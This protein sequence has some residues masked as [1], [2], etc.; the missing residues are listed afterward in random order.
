MAEPRPNPP[1]P[2]LD[3]L[4]DDQSR[5]WHQG[6]RP[7]V[8]DYLR[9]HP[10]LGASPEN[11]LDLIYHELL[12]REHRGESP[13]LEEYLARFPHLDQAL[14][15]QF[16]VHRAAG[17]EETASPDLVGPAAD[18][19]SFGDYEIL[20]RVDEGGMGVVY[21]ARQLSLN[22]VVA[23][24]FV[25]LGGQAGGGELRR[26][27]MEAEN[28]ARL[29]HPNIVPVFEVGQHQGQPYFSM[30]FIDG[31]SLARLVAGREQ[32]AAG[33][34]GPRRAAQL[35]ATVA[36]AVQHAHERGILHRDLKPA[37]VLL[38]PAGSAGQPT[39]P[40][41]TDFGLA[42]RLEGDVGQTLSQS[43]AVV[44]TP[45]Y[46]APE[47]ATAQ[48]ELTTA[49]DVYGLGA[50]LYALLTGRPPFRAASVFETLQQVVEREPTPPRQL[51]RHVHLDLET[52][53]LKCLHKQPAQRYASAQEVADELERF[54]RGADIRARPAGRLELVRRWCRRNPALA[55]AS[56]LAVAALLAVTGVSVW[57]ALAESRHTEQMQAALDVSEGLRRKGNLLLAK[58]YLERGR[59]MGE[60]GH[61]VSGMLLLT[62]GLE[63][64][65]PEDAT[66]QQ[67][68]RSQLAVYGRQAH[69]PRFA[70]HQ[71]G[72]V[73]TVT[74]SP[75]GRTLA[76]GTL[77][78]TAQLWDAGTGKPIGDPLRHQARVQAVAFSPDGRVLL[79]GSSDGTARLW[80]VATGRPFG[81]PLRH[82]E[83]VRR[84]A[85]SPDGRTALTGSW[86]GT[87]RLWEADTGKPIGPLLGHGDRVEVACF[88]PEG[89]AVLTGS[90]DG[91]ARIWD[92]ATGEPT[93]EP[94][95]HQ[96]LVVAAAFSPDGRFVLTGSGDHNARLWDRASG[97]PLGP[98][99]AHRFGV[100][101]VA[102]SANG[103]R[104]VTTTEDGMVQRWAT[105][106]RKPLG[107]PIDHRA[108][109][110]AVA[111]SP[112]GSLLLTGSDDRMARLYDAASGKPIGFPMHH[113]GEV[114]GSRSAPT[115]CS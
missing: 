45:E 114:W 38:Q 115:A 110:S 95:R 93:G 9:Q 23:L 54:L 62:R 69:W 58:N 20:G 41:V 22:R 96:G 113:V 52:I 44:G 91:T 63:I 12:L 33:A 19:T 10:G 105:D 76:V 92:A 71:P 104:F 2:S 46:M 108:A 57:F 1:Q 75:D 32:L 7:W 111:F 24:K 84:V 31:G 56:A 5:R 43:G 89:K 60:K 83:A 112:N 11:L 39:T 90:W 28:V 85:F 66:L 29:D 53:C 3:I 78:G 35:L 49:T 8:E 47:Q 74:W 94:L 98:P 14:R 34:A 86:D 102:F 72:Q 80:Q 48:K 79:T 55:S 50:I 59:A 70:L 27:Q 67:A 99:L 88:D 42:K 30:K 68:I 26:F 37:N 65:P 103:H 107:D 106:T 36:R 81:E 51:N 15:A 6:Q 18:P 64:A 40:L 97:K 13:Q 100:R 77:D 21:K 25:R 101:A 73:C 61:W 16:A 4:L 82:Q 17:A 87:A 109:V